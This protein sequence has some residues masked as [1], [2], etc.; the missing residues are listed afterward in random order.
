MR[1]FLAFIVALTHLK[2]FAPLG[3]L[4]WIEQLGSFEAILGFLLIS[5]YSIG[6]SIQKRPDGYFLRRMWR[7]YPVFL[8][9]TAITYAVKQQA[10][11]GAF[12]WYFISNLFFLGQIVETNSYVGP[13]WTLDLE[14][15]LYC[16]APLLLLL[17]GRTL[18]LLI[19]AS[20]ACY[21]LYT[22]GRTLFQLPH[23]AGTIGGINLPCLAFIWIAGFY[24]STSRQKKRPLMIAGLIFVVHLVLIVTIEFFHRF[25]HHEA[26]AFFDDLPGFLSIALL[27]L[28]VF[29]VFRGV[30][31]HGFHLTLWQSRIA[32]FLGDISY[33]LY[34]VHFAVFLYASRYFSTP[35]PMLLTALGVATAVYFCCDFYSMR[36][37]LVT[38]A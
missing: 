23:Y 4:A 17:R 18:E 5:G 38:A 34:L 7:I 14:V 26:G 1:F 19:G 27:L 11:T 6:H 25:K 33:P 13:A 24:L 3:P 12:A 22:M 37:K 9:A 31:A 8:A 32:R 30:I 21:V 10:W 28:M 20:L 15:W 2:R 35:V 36:R 29:V 16:L